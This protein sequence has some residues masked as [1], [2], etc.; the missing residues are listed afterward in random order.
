MCLNKSHTVFLNVLVYFDLQKQLQQ[1]QIKPQKIVDFFKRCQIHDTLSKKHYNASYWHGQWCVL[2]SS[3]E[4]AD[5]RIFAPIL[6][7]SQ[8]VSQNTILPMYLLNL[9][10]LSKLLHGFL[11]VV[12][13]ICQ[14]WLLD[15][16]CYINVKID[17]WISLIFTWIC[18][19]WWMDSS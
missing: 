2:Y 18:Q 11:L 13:G 15:F 6:T 12:K 19:I 9:L 4:K 10:D 3:L 8:S 5:T 1:I 16:S 14:N 17:T 7:V